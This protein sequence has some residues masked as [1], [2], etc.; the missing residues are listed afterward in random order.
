MDVQVLERSESG[1][2]RG[3]VRDIEIPFIISAIVTTLCE[4]PHV[5]PPSVI[6]S[7]DEPSCAGI[8][9]Y[10]SHKLWVTR[11]TDRQQPT[12]SPTGTSVADMDILPRY[13][14]PPPPPYSSPGT[15]RRGISRVGALT[16]VDSL[17][18]Y[19]FKAG[20]LSARN[21]VARAFAG[22]ALR[23]FRRWSHGSFFFFSFGEPSAGHRDVGGRAAPRSC[24]LLGG[25]STSSPPLV[26]CQTSASC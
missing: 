20:V 1:G 14:P 18:G 24:D 12:P 4:S 9:A 10:I 2:S 6:D 17:S 7:E 16:R 19:Q 22:G 23:C 26:H 15:F 21:A 3:I 8:I 5:S 25:E 11:R 13:T